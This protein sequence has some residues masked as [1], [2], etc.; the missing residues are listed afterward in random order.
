[1][2]AEVLDVRFPHYI[3]IP[4][5][6]EYVRGKR[7]DVDC[8]FCAIAREDPKVPSKL[9]YKN[10]DFMVLLNIYPYNPGHL[11]VAPVKHVEN[12]EELN[13]E[14]IKG[15]F[16]L[17]QRSIK[18]LREVYNPHGFNIGINQGKA[19]G[20]SINHL[21]VHVVP[22]Y[23]GELGFI[24]LSGSRIIVENLEVTLRKLKSKVALL[25]G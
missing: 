7:P 17:V 20:A 6:G 14:E 25:E 19:A 15:L 9:V 10:K 22:R 13:E 12:L 11:M 24:D 2:E 5:K 18:L 16:V 4:E 8:I 23:L 1:M 21:H 3:L